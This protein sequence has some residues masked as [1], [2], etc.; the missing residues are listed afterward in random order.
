M[1]EISNLRLVKGEEWTKVVVDIKSDVKRIDS[2]NIMWVAVKNENAS[3]LNDE[4]YDA[5]LCLPVVMSMYYK[6]DLRIHGKVSRVLYHNV[7]KYVQ[8]IFGF[9]KDGTK[10][11]NIE[12][13]GFAEVQQT[14]K[15]VGTGISCGIDCLQTIYDNYCLEDDVEYKING[16]FNFN[17]GWHG[18]YGNEETYRLFLERSKRNKQ[19]ADDLNLPLYLV[20][21]NLDAFLRP[22]RDQTSYFNL[23]T[24]AVALEKGLSKYYIS[25][26]YSYRDIVRIG[27]SS[28]NIDFSEFGEPLV[29]SLLRTK[30]FELIS[31]GYQYDRTGKTERIVGWDIA[32]KDLNVC[33][34]NDNKENC[35]ICGK[36]IRTLL[37]LEAMDKLD[38][39][40]EIFNIAAYK[41]HSFEYKCKMSLIGKDGKNGFL[42][43]LYRY[44]KLKEKKLP[45]RFI[46][47]VYLVPS[48]LV[49]RIKK[50][51]R[52]TK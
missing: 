18:K 47:L 3:M 1:I 25:G 50:L 24:C 51:F 39:Y 34:V 38:D 12:V 4:T 28:R 41:K 21:S 33:C 49:G 9:F 7:R 48:V 19:A 11:I 42:S 43:D 45:P 37:A 26:S 20:D 13:D 29:V 44:Y 52:K 22:L 30:N 10:I 40:K 15:I 36:C 17:C 46:A 23:Y 31:D 14:S 27:F 32:K 35:S 2:E 6:T 16:L 5:F 8:S